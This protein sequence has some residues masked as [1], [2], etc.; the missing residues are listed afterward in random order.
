MA[1]NMTCLNIGHDVF[2]NWTLDVSKIIV[3]I[4]GHLIF[5]INAII[6]LDLKKD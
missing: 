5:S 4:R 2:T 3:R 6:Y 1:P